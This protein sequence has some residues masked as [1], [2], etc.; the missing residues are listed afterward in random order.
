MPPIPDLSNLGGMKQKK[1]SHKKGKH[2][3]KRRAPEDDNDIE[4]TDFKKQ[5]TS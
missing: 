4:K 2:L 1:E 5:K 3:G